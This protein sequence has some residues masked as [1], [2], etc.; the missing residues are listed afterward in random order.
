MSTMFKTAFL[1]VGMLTVLTGLL[2]PVA[3]TGLAQLFFAKQAHGSLTVDE[4]R[5][6]GS[7]LIGRQFDDPK[8]FW[9]RPSATSP[10]PYNSGASSGS[11]YGSQSPEH[12][13]AMATRREALQGADPGNTQPVPIDLLTAS[14]SGLDPHITPDAAEYQAGR[15]AR[16]RHLDIDAVRTLI[17][18][19]TEGRQLGIL[20]QPVVNVAALNRAL[21]RK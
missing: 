7:H 4:G 1:M 10:F 6:V 19:H 16:L 20:G 14:G 3:M 5:V 9:S 21:D 11:N 17:A 15:I 18:A 8:Y 12:N 2:Y 13:K